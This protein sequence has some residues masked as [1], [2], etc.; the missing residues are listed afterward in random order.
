MCILHQKIDF[1]LR[2]IC[3]R[4]EVYFTACL[5]RNSNCKI[6]IKMYLISIPE[7]EFLSF[8]EVLKVLRTAQMRH[9]TG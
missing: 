5:L 8:E 3:L 7:I 4:L 9:N 1:G 6:C 2:M